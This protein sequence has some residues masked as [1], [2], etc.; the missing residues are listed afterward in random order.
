[1]SRRVSRSVAAALLA[2]VLS[3][4]TPAAFAASRDG[5]SDPGFGSQIVRVIKHFAKKLGIIGTYEDFASPA[6]P[7]P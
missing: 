4:S 2:L 5:G 7:K 3:L 6:P 1:M